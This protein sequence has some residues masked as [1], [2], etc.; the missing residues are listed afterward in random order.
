MPEAP[1]V[2]V[3]RAPHQAS[4]LA[5]ALRERGFEVVAIPSI[6][7]LP[8]LDGYASLDDALQ[9]IRSFDWLIFTSANAV[10]VFAARHRE[11]GQS[12]PN[13]LRI[14]VIGN[15]TAR[16]AGDA[17]LNVELIP[18]RAVGESLAEELAPHAKG[19]RMLLVRADE[20]R[21]VLPATL[22]SAG[23]DVTLAVAYCTVV[24]E[25]S[26]AAL[27]REVAT[28]DAVTFTSASSARNLAAL[29][30][31]AE[32]SLP[33]RAVLASI[34]PVTSTAMREMGWDRSV[35]ADEAS[36]VSLAESLRRHFAGC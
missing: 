20:G 28:L 10:E 34:G 19:K 3:T 4:A 27:Q 7:I 32:V 15:A 35:E 36:V 33:E 31:R 5:D 23:A 11:V 13:S 25:D 8:P 29:M 22:R 16:A 12:L 2:L 24:A 21:E 6:A 30:E 26:V 17:G 18:Q 14:A 9:Q 1:R